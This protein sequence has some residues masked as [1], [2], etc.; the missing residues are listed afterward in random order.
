MVHRPF[1]F[2]FA[3]DDGIRKASSSRTALIFR[4]LL[5]AIPVLFI[6]VTPHVLPREERAG[7]S[8]LHRKENP[9]GNHG[10]TGKAVR[11][12]RLESPSVRAYMG[13]G[14]RRPEHLDAA[15]ATAR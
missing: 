8:V 10:G 14:A 2:A 9:A 6:V 15:I 11:P 13:S 7:Q 3:Q 12:A 4:R 1:S 5:Q